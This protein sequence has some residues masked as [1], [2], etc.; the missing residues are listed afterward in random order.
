VNYIQSKFKEKFARGRG[1][2]LATQE[3]KIADI[4]RLIDRYLTST[5]SITEFLFL[6]WAYIHTRCDN[7]L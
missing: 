6:R 4:S 3:D 5:S 2:S 1:D 7:E